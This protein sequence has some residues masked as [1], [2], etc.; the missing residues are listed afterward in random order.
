MVSKPIGWSERSV[1]DAEFDDPEQILTNLGCDRG[2]VERMMGHFG[3]KRLSV[4]MRE[5]YAQGE[6]EQGPRVMQ[7]GRKVAGGRSGWFNRVYRALLS[8]LGPFEGNARSDNPSP[9]P[10]RAWLEIKRALAT[11]GRADFSTRAIAETVDA[12]GGVTALRSRIDQPT[13]RR[14]FEMTYKQLVQG[15]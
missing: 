1:Q 6:I 15:W 5:E 7:D 13:T 12:L 9:V 10:A 2:M 14:D 8:E 4:L 3:R 11:P